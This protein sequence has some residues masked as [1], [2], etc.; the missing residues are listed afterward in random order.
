[1]RLTVDI[2]EDSLR[3]LQKATGE[4]KKSPAVQKALQEYLH[5]R[6]VQ[7]YLS[8]V[9]EGHVDYPMTNDELED[10]LDNDSDIHVGE[11]DAIDC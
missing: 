7:E 6:K 2:D 5:N 9:R 10:M 1:M 4:T 11:S 3:E 8:L